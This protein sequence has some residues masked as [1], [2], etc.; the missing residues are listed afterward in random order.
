LGLDLL[1]GRACL[2]VSLQPGQ[3]IVLMLFLQSPSDIAPGRTVRA[4]RFLLSQ[5]IAQT[6]NQ[7]PEANNGFGTH[8]LVMVSAQQVLVIF[9]QDLNRPANG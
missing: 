2:E 5:E 1:D 8:Q 9:K 4:Q 6:G 3:E 7:G